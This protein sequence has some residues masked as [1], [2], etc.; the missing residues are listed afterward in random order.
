MNLKG[1]TFS[2]LKSLNV[3]IYEFLIVN[4]YNC[5]KIYISN[6][7][8]TPD[9]HCPSLWIN[10]DNHK[11]YVY[12]MDKRINKTQINQS[13]AILKEETFRDIKW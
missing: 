11:K 5:L 2:F 7:I 9:R 3:A 1:Y 10:K 6:F 4:F 13:W 12:L 8:L